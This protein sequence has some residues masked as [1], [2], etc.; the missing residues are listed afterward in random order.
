MN[1]LWA[2]IGYINYNSFYILFCIG[3]VGGF[4]LTEMERFV[5]VDCQEVYYIIDKLELPPFPENLDETESDD[6][7]IEH[8]LSGKEVVERL[9]KLNYFFYQLDKVEKFIEKNLKLADEMRTPIKELS[10]GDDLGYWNGVYQYLKKLEQELK[11]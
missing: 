9:N 2:R 6:W 1:D 3:T 5:Q 10:F 7:M 4:G 8:S 11:E